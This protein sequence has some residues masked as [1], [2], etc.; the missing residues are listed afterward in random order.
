MTKSS[1]TKKELIADQLRDTI[2]AGELL[3]GD[4]LTQDDLAEQFDVSATPIREAIQILIAEG[5]LS[6]SPYKGVQVAEIRMDDVREVYLIRCELEALATRLAVPNL[7]L[8]DVKKLTEIQVQIERHIEQAD[9]Q[10]LRKFNYEFHMVIYRAAEMPLLFTLIR[11]LWTRFPWDTLHVLPG[12]AG[13][14]SLEHRE[15]MAAINDI[16]EDLAAQRMR[17]HIEDSMIALD[18]YLADNS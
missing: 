5:V 16:D 6:H 18:R 11:N 10:S 9:L 14:S 8:S 1:K 7:R 2:I 13:Q 17:R 12:R 3:P 4:R 15:I